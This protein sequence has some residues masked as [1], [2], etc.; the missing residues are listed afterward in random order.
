MQKVTDT[1]LSTQAGSK[2]ALVADGSAALVGIGGLTLTGNLAARVNRMG[3]TIDRTVMVQGTPVKVKF[4]SAADVT[5]FSGD[6]SLGIS[7]FVTVT[8]AFAFE[9][10]SQTVGTVTT[11]EIT[12]AAAN[13]NIFLG[14]NAGTADATGVQITG[15]KLGL[16]MQKVTD[17]TLSTQADSKYALV[18]EGAAALVGVDGL[19]LG[20]TLAARVN[21]MGAPINKTIDVQ[22]TPDQVRRWPRHHAVRWHGFAGRIRF[23]HGQRRLCVRTDIANRGDG[24]NYRD[25]GGGRE[26]QHLPWGQCWDRRRHWRCDFECQTRPGAQQDH[27]HRAVDAGRF[28]VCLGGRR[29]RGAGGY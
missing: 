2:Y 5:Q 18:A 15:A 8:G 12:A 27:R 6:V 21:R 14:A 23:R 17:T 9:R 28:E 11:T 3:G 1:T 22:G 26:Y 10:S 25:H 19:T 7:G 13:I 20:G 24:D 29:H 4:D 16:V